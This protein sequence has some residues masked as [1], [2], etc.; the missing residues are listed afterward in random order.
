M[1]KIVS[2][3]PLVS[4][5]DSRAGNAVR[6]HLGWGVLAT[7]DRVL[8]PVALDWANRVSDLEVLLASVGP[9]GVGLVER[10][11][12]AKIDVVGLKQPAGNH[13]AVVR[14]SHRSI[15][16]PV[17]RRLSRSRLQ[18]HLDSGGDMASAL[19][20]LGVIPE[21]VNKKPAEARGRSRSGK[22]TARHHCCKKT[23]SILRATSG[24]GGVTS[25]GCD[26]GPGDIVPDHAPREWW[27]DAPEETVDR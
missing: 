2:P 23:C 12:I 18:D 13:V 3:D 4:I 11:K 8:V 21:W 22:S 16:P 7:S 5:Q 24:F 9:R 25:F 10:V 6:G 15:H 1:P 27:M 14:L 19:S 26:P 20:A 17:V